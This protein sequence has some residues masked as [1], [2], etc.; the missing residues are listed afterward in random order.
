[1][2][3]MFDVNVYCS[4]MQDFQLFGKAVNPKAYAGCLRTVKNKLITTTKKL[5]VSDSLGGCFNQFIFVE[6]C[7]ENGIFID[8]VISFT[9]TSR[10][11]FVF[12]STKQIE[13]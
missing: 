11:F 5:V 13:E 10:K 9:L 7:K 8:Y 6:Q 2:K 3:M 1:M 4:T 12:F